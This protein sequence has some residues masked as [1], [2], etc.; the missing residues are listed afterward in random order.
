[1]AQAT[2]SE[3]G[4]ASSPLPQTGAAVEL[5]ASTALGTDPSTVSGVVSVAQFRRVTLWIKASVDAAGA[6][7]HIVPLVSAA[8]SQPAIGD[9]SWFGLSERDAEATAT[10]LAGSV[11]TGADYTIAPEWAVVTM[12][13]IVIRTE[14]GDANTNEIR[15]AVTLDVTHARWLYVACEEVSAAMTLAIDWSGSL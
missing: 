13:P 3:I 2:L 4:G 15:M 5:L 14:A 9:D 10:L 1:M 7:A 8:R 6:Y 12:R 11:T